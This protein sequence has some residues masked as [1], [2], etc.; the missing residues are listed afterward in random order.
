MTNEDRRFELVKIAFA[1]VLD[2]NVFTQSPP[3]HRGIKQWVVELADAVLAEMEEQKSELDKGLAG[4]REA[5]PTTCETLT[6]A[7]TNTLEVLREVRR[8]LRYQLVGELTFYASSPA[9]NSLSTGFRE[10]YKAGCKVGC[11]YIDRA[12]T[13]VEKGDDGGK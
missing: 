2:K 1:K 5:V 7:P 6:H 10:G 11:N 13:D 3:Y 8:K 4:S 12:I 9:L